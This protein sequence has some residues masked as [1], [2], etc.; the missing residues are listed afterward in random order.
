[1]GLDGYPRERLSNARLGL[2]NWQRSWCWRASVSLL[3]QPQVGSA[4]RC[5]ALLTGSQRIRVRHTHKCTHALK[6]KDE[7]KNKNEADGDTRNWARSSS[8]NSDYAPGVLPPSGSA[9]SG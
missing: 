5:S 7:D 8:T 1:M 4:L 6:E 9:S 3:Q 2:A